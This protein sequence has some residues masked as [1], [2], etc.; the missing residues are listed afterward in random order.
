[1]K[2]SFLQRYGCCVE[3]CSYYTIDSTMLLYHIQTLHPDRSAYQ[4]PHCPDDIAPVPFDDLEFHLRCHADLLYK[5]PHCPM[6]HW[7]KRTAEKHVTDAHPGAKVMAFDIRAEVK[8]AK[9]RKEKGKGAAAAASTKKEA[10]AYKPYKCGLCDSAEETI[11]D[12]RRHCQ[13]VHEHANQFK[14]SR[15]D[16]SSDAKTE[17]ETHFQQSHKEALNSVV[18]IRIFYADPTSGGDP[19]APLVV[20]DSDEKPWAPLWSR[21]MPGLKHIRYVK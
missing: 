1:M 20:N 7:Q 3:D 9:D 12:I 19:A 2:L 6:Y 5:C 17:V 8:A 4:C 13:T 14:C 15:C 18:M 16:V 10:W 11:Q 21:D